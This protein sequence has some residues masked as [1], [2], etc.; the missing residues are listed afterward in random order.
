MFMSLAFSQS[1]QTDGPLLPY[2]L[3]AVLKDST[4]SSIAS[5]CVVKS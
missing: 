2:C 1:L 5:I 4:Q 3:A